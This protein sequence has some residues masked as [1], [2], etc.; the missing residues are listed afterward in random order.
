MIELQESSNEFLVMTHIQRKYP[1]LSLVLP[2]RFVEI[3]ED[4]CKGCNTCFKPFPLT[5]NF[6]F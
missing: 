5:V 2:G 6:L 3:I 4:I 1:P